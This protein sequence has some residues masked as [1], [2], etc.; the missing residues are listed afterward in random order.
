M[1]SRKSAARRRSPR[2]ITTS[3]SNHYSKRDYY[4]KPRT[5][6][7]RSVRQPLNSDNYDYIISLQ[8]PQ[9]LSY[10]F[11]HGLNTQWLNIWIELNL[12]YENSKWLQC[13]PVSQEPL[14]LPTLEERSHPLTLRSALALSNRVKRTRNMMHPNYVEL[15][16]LFGLANWT[17]KLI[18]VRGRA[19]KATFDLCGMKNELFTEL[20][21]LNGVRI[22]LTLRLE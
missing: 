1:I 4:A 22:D 2:L 3:P 8:E 9:M 16:W 14:N 15:L 6:T 5:L 17:F 18:V 19:F 21:L 7:V 11:F 12:I 20:I 13:M 10:F